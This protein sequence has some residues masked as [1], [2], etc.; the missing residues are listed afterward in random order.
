M[1]KHR[2][3]A[4]HGLPHLVLPKFMLLVQSSRQAA[5]WGRLENV[6]GR[7]GNGV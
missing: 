2:Y 4:A 3:K 7:D 5:I 1:Y 6:E